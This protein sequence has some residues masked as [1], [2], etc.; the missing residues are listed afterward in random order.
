MAFIKDIYAFAGESGVVSRSQNEEADTQAQPLN[1]TKAFGDFL[2][3]T[4]KNYSRAVVQY[5]GNVLRLHDVAADLIYE[6]IWVTDLIDFGTIVEDTEAYTY[7][8]NAYI[9]QSVDYTAVTDPDDEGINIA[10]ATPPITLLPNEE[11]AYLTT[12]YAA[13]PAEQYSVY[14]W[15]INGIQF[16]TLV[17]GERVLVF[18][19]VPNWKQGVNFTLGYETVIVA[20]RNLYE[21][22]RSQWPSPKREV[23]FN[24][25]EQGIVAERL[26]NTLRFAQGRYVGVNVY[27]EIF[28]TSG[29]IT[30][31]TDIVSAVSLTD[32]YNLQNLCTKIAIIDP[33]NA[34]GELKSIESIA[35]DTITLTSEVQKTFDPTTAIMFPVYVGVMMN[36]NAKSITDNF[37]SA[38]VQFREVFLGLGETS[39]PDV[40][41]STQELPSFIVPNMRSGINSRTIQARDIFEYFGSGPTLIS[42]QDRR[43]DVLSFNDNVQGMDNIASLTEF[44]CQHRGRLARFFVQPYVEAFTLVSSQGS[45]ANSFDVVRNGYQNIWSADDYLYLIIDNGT[46][47]ERVRV[48]D[49]VED[50]TNDELTITFTPATTAATSPTNTY[51]ARSYLMRFDIDKLNFAFVSNEVARVPMRFYEVPNERDE[52]V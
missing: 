1:L 4:T 48:T 28:W 25:E 9:G 22:R 49:V 29:T 44:F 5:T 12:V 46:T 38:D 43:P 52:V 32:R 34:V 35:G 24:I 10:Y 3:T 51:I 7:I 40:P 21:Q 8:W 33:Y 15:L 16:E 23:S 37:T 30:G 14:I 17:K 31:E 18:P 27:H 19:F 50:E 26:L 6:R 39:P 13:G 45:G 41:A 20:G 36:H 2:D 42:L 47:I 11:V